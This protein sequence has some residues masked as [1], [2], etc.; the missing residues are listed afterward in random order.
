MCVAC[1]RI[2][3]H[4]GLCALGCIHVRAC[5]HARLHT[6]T[7]RE[8][9]RTENVALRQKQGFTN[10]DLLVVDFEQRKQELV[11]MRDKIGE[12][13]Q[14]YQLLAAVVE[15]QRESGE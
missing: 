10:S 2:N 5:T 9:L 3:A 6:R 12:L 7:E 1:L 13:R 11:V 14:R 15:R 8:D 4:S